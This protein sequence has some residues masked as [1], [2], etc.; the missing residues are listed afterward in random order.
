MQSGSASLARLRPGCGQI[1][2][3]SC[4]IRARRCSIFGVSAEPQRFSWHT[5]QPPA[6]PTSPQP[7]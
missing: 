2:A 3:R 5:H 1:A 4:G 6:A 7:Q